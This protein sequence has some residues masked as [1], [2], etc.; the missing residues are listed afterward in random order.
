MKNREPATGGGRD[1]QSLL[2]PIKN[3]HLSERNLD[4]A[5]E[6]L[7]LVD[8]TFFHRSLVWLLINIIIVF[9]WDGWEY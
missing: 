1:R 5:P 4:T 7:L 9:H 6:D 3:G 8:F 2:D